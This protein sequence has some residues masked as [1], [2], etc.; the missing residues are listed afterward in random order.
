V[1]SATASLKIGIVV[2]TIA[3]LLQM[4]AADSTARGVSRDQPLKLAALEGLPASQKEA[5]MGVVGVVGWKRDGEGRIVGVEGSAVRIPGLLSILVSGDFLHPVAASD[6]E[7]QGL[8]DLPSNEFLR[9]RHPGASDEELAK[10]R[11]QYWPNVPVVF[12]TY[13]LMISLGVALVTIALLACVLWWTG[14]LW[15]TKSRFTRA[16][17]S[18]LVFTPVLSEVAIQAGWFTAEMGR[19]P[20]VVYQVLKTSDAASA[21]VKAP[22]VLSSIIMFSVV[23]LLL[24]VLFIGLFIRTVRKGPATEAGGT[25]LPEKWQPLSLKAGRQTKG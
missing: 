1:E 24:A 6:T 12:Q 4:L 11:P 8:A 18:V 16:F 21:V 23:Y 20:W 15:D 22:Q 2:A 10:L 17:L 5:P 19:Q 3:S 7:V 13:H 9:R 25:D 14:K